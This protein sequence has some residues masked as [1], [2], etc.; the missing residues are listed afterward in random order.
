MSHFLKN[1]KVRILLIV[2]TVIVALASL[3]IVTIQN[4]KKSGT[5]VAYIE[6]EKV[7]E[8]LPFE[9]NGG[10]SLYILIDFPK[11]DLKKCPHDQ[12]IASDLYAVAEL[13]I[14]SLVMETDRPCDNP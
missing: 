6:I 2:L 1:T 13:S 12:G 11:V 8:Y 4:M 10:S 9:V 7:G 14:V 3:S 5:R